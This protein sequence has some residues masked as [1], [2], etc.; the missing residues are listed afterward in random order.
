M[1]RIQ[2]RHKDLSSEA[3]NPEEDRVD[4]GIYSTDNDVWAGTELV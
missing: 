3:V 4:I 2:Q 1:H